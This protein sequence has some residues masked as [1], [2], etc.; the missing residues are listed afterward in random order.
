LC[1][2]LWSRRRNGLRNNTILIKELES[3]RALSI[4]DEL[5]ACSALGIRQCQRGSL[6]PGLANEHSLSH[7]CSGC[8]TEFLHGLGLL[9]SVSH[10]LNAL[11][12]VYYLAERRIGSVPDAQTGRIQP[13]TLSILDRDSL[14]LEESVECQQRA[15]VRLTIFLFAIKTQ[16]AAFIALV[17]E[18][19]H[20]GRPRPR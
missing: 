2:I 16:A 10:F 9:G 6:L 4:D 12:L 15:R 17:V 13:V 1:R 11:K 8:F 5:R 7:T 18:E 3:C 19:Q 14:I 20:S